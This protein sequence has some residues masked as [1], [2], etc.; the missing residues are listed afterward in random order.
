MTNGKPALRRK[1]VD[2]G[3]ASINA[4]MTARVVGD[5]SSLPPLISSTAW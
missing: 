2:C 3:S 5:A 4:S 1:T